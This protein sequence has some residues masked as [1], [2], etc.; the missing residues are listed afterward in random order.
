M[1][2]AT[3]RSS[4]RSDS[5]VILFMDESANDAMKVTGVEVAVLK[6]ATA[7]HPDSMKVHPAT[8]DRNL[9][10]HCLACVK[11]CPSISWDGAKGQVVVNEVSCKG[12][13]ICGSV[14]P[15]CAISQR[16]FSTG[17]VFD[18]LDRLWSDSGNEHGI[19]SCASCPIQAAGIAG[20]QVPAVHGQ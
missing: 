4:S 5:G 19:E 9:C 3:G 20:L 13:G 2:E 8:V 14:C 6:A 7:P 18:V 11:L 16:Q 10:V 12:C 1:A 15:A 17:M